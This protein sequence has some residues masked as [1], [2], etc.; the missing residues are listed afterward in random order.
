MSPGL[1]CAPQD[2]LA[3]DLA[4][5][6]SASWPG[7]GFMAAQRDPASSTAGSTAASCSQV[8]QEDLWLFP[9]EPLLFSPFSPQN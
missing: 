6:L 5:L 8:P 9:T 1:E 7:S 3:L 2:L 4:P